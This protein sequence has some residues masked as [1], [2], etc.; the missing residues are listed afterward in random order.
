MNTIN[1]KPPAFRYQVE[2]DVILHLMGESTYLRR[3]LRYIY[4]YKLSLFL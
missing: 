2:S 1:T 4:I 3:G